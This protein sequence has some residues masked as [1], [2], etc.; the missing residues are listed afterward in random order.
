MEI[1]AAIVK[2]T[3]DTHAHVQV[4]MCG[5]ITS[6]TTATCKVIFGPD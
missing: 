6:L 1:V 4:V 5:F 2:V 3:I